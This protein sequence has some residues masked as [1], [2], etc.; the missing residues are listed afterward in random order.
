PQTREAGKPYFEVVV[1]LSEADAEFLRYGMTGSVS[2][3]GRSELF[4]KAV[5]RRFIRFWNQLYQ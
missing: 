4:G 1:E 3:P 2:F 5:A